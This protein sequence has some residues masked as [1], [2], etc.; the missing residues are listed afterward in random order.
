M[1]FH[2][3]MAYVAYSER[4]WQLH[5]LD[6]AGKADSPDADELHEEM[7]ED[8]NT[9]S[10]DERQRVGE[11]SHDFFSLHDEEPALQGGPPAEEALRQYRDA[12][13]KSEWNATLTALRYCHRLVPRARLA[14]VRAKCWEQLGEQVA[15]NRFYERAA[16]HKEALAT[17][18]PRRSGMRVDFDRDVF[19][20]HGMP[21]RGFAEVG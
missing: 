12:F 16:K 9:L 1:M 18:P 19:A 13:A 17:P 6:A 11:L 10:V 3:N 7:V 8:W 15:A 14:D 4:L 5:E 20:V 2:T 21:V